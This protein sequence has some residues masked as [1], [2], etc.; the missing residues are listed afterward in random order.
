M[1]ST[2]FALGRGA[3]RFA[4]RAPTPL[5]Q[6]RARGKAA[7]AWH[8]RHHHLVEVQEP[9]GPRH[10]IGLQACQA[11]W[12]KSP[13]TSGRR[14]V[15]PRRERMHDASTVRFA[16]ASLVDE[17]APPGLDEPWSASRRGLHSPA[18]S[19]LRRLS[20]VQMAA[21]G[22]IAG[23]AIGGS[24]TTPRR[25]GGACEPRFT[26]A[27]CL[28]RRHATGNRRLTTLQKMALRR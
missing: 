24:L 23:P 11:A 25:V 18:C 3:S 8:A 5:T 19:L 12:A 15:T 7:R 26:R 22:P 14:R 2:G 16:M 1:R 6:S 28:D 20:C 21:S 9:R 10:H 17:R 13:R 27:N 4:H